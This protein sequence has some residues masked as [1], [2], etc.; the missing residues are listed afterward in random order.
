MGHIKEPEG[1]DFFV[2]SKP[3]TEKD[4]REIS[5]IIAHYKSTG[6][7]KKIGSQ[8]KSVNSKKNSSVRENI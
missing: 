4:K 5:E 1:V 7:K 2:D 3:L 8:T 6:R